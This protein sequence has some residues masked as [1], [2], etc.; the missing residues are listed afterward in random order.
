MLF[1]RYDLGEEHQRGKERFMNKER[2]EAVKTARR[3]RMAEA[4]VRAAPERER[5]GLA[6]VHVHFLSP[7]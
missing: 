5:E 7:G 2:D 4:Q 6:S 1:L 3:M